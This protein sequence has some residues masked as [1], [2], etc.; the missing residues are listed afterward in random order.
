M[1]H[2]A[3]VSSLELLYAY[4]YNKTCGKPLLMHNIEFTVFAKALLSCQDENVL[5]F[6]GLSLMVHSLPVD[7]FHELRD[8]PQTNTYTTHQF[9]VW[10]LSLLVWFTCITC[11]PSV[12]KMVVN[13][14]YS[15]VV[16]NLINNHLAS[17]NHVVFPIFQLST[18]QG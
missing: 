10:V 11:K 12:G 13:S 5:F 18:Q 3:T 2:L 14:V 17:V 16:P 4:V 7:I 8:R 9:C 1:E 15:F 6:C